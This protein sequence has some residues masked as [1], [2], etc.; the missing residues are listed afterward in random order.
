MD[1]FTI[2]RKSLTVFVC[3]ICGMLP[4]LG[5]PVAIYGA[6]LWRRVRVRHKGEWNP[7][8]LY[9]NIGGVLS[10]LGLLN[11]CVIVFVV[12]LTIGYNAFGGFP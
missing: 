12:V 2:I 1:I 3:G 10:V 11:S 6:L 4:V 9:L 8:S 7:A 5:L